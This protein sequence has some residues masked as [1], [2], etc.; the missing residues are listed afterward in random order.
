MTEQTSEQTTQT[1]DKKKSYLKLAFVTLLTG[2]LL[3]A[4]FYQYETGP[5]LKEQQ[6]FVVEKGMTVRSIAEKAKREHLVRSE[7]ILYSLLTISHDPTKIQAGNYIFNPSDDVFSVATKLSTSALEQ[8]LTRL[9]LP[10]GITRKEMADIASEVLPILN[11]DEYITGT[12]N[13]EGFLFPDTYFVPDTFTATDLIKLQLKTYQDKT[14]DLKQQISN[15]S[16]SEYEILTLAS[17]VEHEANDETSMKMVAGILL[18]R[19]DIG[20]ALQAD[21]T[22]EYVLDSSIG[23]LTAGEF[24]KKLRELDSPYN[25]YK[26]TGLTPTPIGNPGLM[27]IKAVLSPIKSDYFYYLTDKAGDF[28][29][30]KTLDGHNQNIQKYL[31]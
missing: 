29:Y 5:A 8:D 31:R 4:F 2:I 3:F 6:S 13:L 11:R 26:H 17:I 1:T 16:L 15:Y 10:E 14:A 27:S 20:M 9:T 7:L 22:V 18:N 21:A 12:A 25:T 30:A 19:L 24:A 28:Y 23:E